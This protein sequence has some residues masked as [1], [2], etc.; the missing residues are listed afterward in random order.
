MNPSHLVPKEFHGGDAKELQTA[1]NSLCEDG[2]KKRW[3]KIPVT[4]V[5]DHLTESALLNAI[6]QIG[7]ETVL[8]ALKTK[9][10]SK[11]TK[12]GGE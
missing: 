10:T 2:K 6:E 11:N 1:L 7:K 9:A 8:E 3:T 12:G 4:G 5:Y